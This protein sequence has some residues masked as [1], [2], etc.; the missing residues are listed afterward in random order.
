MADQDAALAADHRYA[1]IVEFVRKT[2]WAILPGTLATIKAILAERAG[3]YR[4]T[5]EEIAARLGAR[6]R[7]EVQLDIDARRAGPNGSRDDPPYQV[8]GGVAVI[9]IAGVIVP[10]ANL[11]TQISGGTSAEELRAAVGQALDDEEVTS[12]LFDVD[13]PGGSTDQL[14]ETAKAIRDARGRKPMVAVANT[15]AASAAYWLASQADEVVVTQSG[16]VGSVG[17]FAAH[18]DLSG[19]LAKVGVKTTLISYG[20]YKTEANPFEPLSDDAH[21]YIQSVVD[22]FGHMF[23]ADVAKGRRVSVQTVRDDFGKGRVV[24][25]KNAVRA[26]MADRVDTFEAT[27]RRLARGAV[28]VQPAEPDVAI[29]PGDVPADGGGTATVYLPSLH[30]TSGLNVSSFTVAPAE[31]V[32][33]TAQASAVADDA[34]RLTLRL[35]SLAEAQRGEL[36]AAKRERLEAC[37]D[38][39]RAAADGIDEVLDANQA[40]STPAITDAGYD[41]ELDLQLSRI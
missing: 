10:R 8:A 31:P 6:P 12:L 41:A 4:P 37:S 1:R 22:E 23:E 38:R 26:G 13:S 19:A 16:E 15:L 3:G 34:E 24:T 36:T 29:E 14:P 25:A 9:P 5:D 11:F 33:F 35:A 17:V 21:A 30:A 28:Q 40:N 27:L 20:E 7:V 39:L 18:D 32:P 2:P